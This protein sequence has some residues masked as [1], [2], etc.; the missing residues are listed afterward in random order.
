RDMAADVDDERG[1]WAMPADLLLEVGERDAEVLTVAVDV[2]DGAA[3]R[4]DRQRV[5]HEGVRRAEDDATAHVGEAERG[6]RGAGPTRNGHGADAVPARPLGFERLGRRA[7][8]PDL[9]LQDVVPERMQQL[10]IA[11]IESDSEGLI[12]GRGSGRHARRTL[13]GAEAWQRAKQQ[14][15]KRAHKSAR[16]QQSTAP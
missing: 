11:E 5:R 13:T 6:Q 1:P 12:R 14:T 4:R 16:R 9:A 15:R 10:P 7:L 8:R 3:G 2:L